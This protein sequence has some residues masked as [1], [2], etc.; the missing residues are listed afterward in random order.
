LEAR[1]KRAVVNGSVV[2]GVERD[3]VSWIDGGANVE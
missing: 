3:L 1:I 2:S